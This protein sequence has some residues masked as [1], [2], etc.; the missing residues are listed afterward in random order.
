MNNEAV[1]LTDEQ[2]QMYRDWIETQAAG[3]WDADAAESIEVSLTFTFCS[4]GRRVQ[5]RLG[6]SMLLIEDV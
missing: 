5:A 1:S 6:S 2:W 3:L 4:I